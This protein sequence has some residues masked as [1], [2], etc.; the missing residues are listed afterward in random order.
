MNLGSVSVALC[1]LA[2]S[3][4]LVAQTGA[5]TSMS[6]GRSIEVAVA[7]DE[8]AFVGIDVQSVEVERN[9]T[10]NVTLLT[11]ENRFDHSVDLDVVVTGAED[12]QRLNVTAVDAP[13]SLNSGERG[14]VV[15]TVECANA[16]T[17]EMLT[18]ALSASGGGTSVKLPRDMNAQCV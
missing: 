6:A 17:A 16:T 10:E 5:V 7:D 2:L 4:T 15:A 14:S 9:A 8:D 1:A 3:M 12:N 18:V 11:V 13:K